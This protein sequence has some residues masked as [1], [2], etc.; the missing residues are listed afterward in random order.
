MGRP[1]KHGKALPNHIRQREY[2]AQRQFEIAAVARTL[3][4]VLEVCP[5]AR[6]L[7][8]GEEVRRGMAYLL[9]LDI[10]GAL[11]RFERLVGPG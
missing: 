5:E 2:H 4:A 10:S 9:R 3:L 11:D 8:R 1:P 6:Q 7:V